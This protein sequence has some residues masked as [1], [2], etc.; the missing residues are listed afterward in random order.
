[1]S[2][3]A[4]RIPSLLQIAIPAVTIY[5]LYIT[6]ESPRWLVAMKRFD[7]ARFMLIRHHAGDD[8]T[9]ALVEFEFEEITRIIASEEEFAKT[10]SYADM[11]RTRGNRH[12]LFISVS[13]GIFSQWNGIGLVSY[14]LV[15]ILESIGITSVSN[16][17]MISGFIQLWKLIFAVA[18]AFSV[19]RVAWFVV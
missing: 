18:A 2:N 15:P 14:Y 17:T 12:R 6:P 19:D 10:A 8:E 16:Q 5:G 11:L 4:W 9:S 13:L 3:W 7:E 1:M